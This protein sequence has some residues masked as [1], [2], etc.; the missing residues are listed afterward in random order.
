MMP[1]TTITKPRYLRFTSLCLQS[2]ASTTSNARPH[3]FPFRITLV[4]N[5]SSCQRL[6]TVKLF[7]HFCPQN[8]LQVF[9]VT[10]TF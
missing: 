5:I 7:T 3:L 8:F 1:I 6:F 10:L 4:G 2:I 9:C